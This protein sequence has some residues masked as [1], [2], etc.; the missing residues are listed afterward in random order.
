MQTVTTLDVLRNSVDELRRDGGP[1]ALVPT[2]GALHEGHLTLVREAKAKAAHV[3]ASIFVNP[4]QFDQG[5]DLARYPRREA[6]D[7]R[8]LTEAGCD[9]PTVLDALSE[10]LVPAEA[11]WMV[12]TLAG[13]RP[14]TLLRR[15]V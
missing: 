6:S 14:G 15:H 8:L 11:C 10:P 1:I 9:H 5:D 7:V 13:G 12:E 4:R 3:I 2:M